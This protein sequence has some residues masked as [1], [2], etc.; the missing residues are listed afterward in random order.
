MWV[1][2]ICSSHN[3]AVALLRDGR[4]QV[5]IQAERLS[6]RKREMTPV[7]KPNA[8]VSNFVP[9]LLTEK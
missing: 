9:D 7:L 8:V 4:V 5:A 6:R 3:G 2:G 1:L